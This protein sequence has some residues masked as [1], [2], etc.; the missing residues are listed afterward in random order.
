MLKRWNEQ[1]YNIRLILNTYDSLGIDLESIDIPSPKVHSLD[2]I[3]KALIIKEFECL[4][5]RAAE[6]RVPDLLGVRIDHSVLHFWEKKLSPRIE[7]IMNRILEKSHSIDYSV[8]FVDSTIF[9][10]KKEK[11]QNYKQ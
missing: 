4:S 10:N 1:A 5:L 8:S 9:T 11:A 6:N 3:I 7:E 2:I